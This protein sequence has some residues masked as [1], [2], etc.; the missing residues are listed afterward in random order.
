MLWKE[1]KTYVV[2]KIR[3]LFLQ[4]PSNLAHV[5]LGVNVSLQVLDYVQLL[6][7][8]STLDVEGSGFWSDVVQLEEYGDYWIIIFIVF[9]KN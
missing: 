2:L 9:S 7:T 3:I 6:S 5:R 1:N 8:R 4:Y